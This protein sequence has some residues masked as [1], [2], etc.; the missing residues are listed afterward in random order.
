MTIRYLG[1]SSR[2]DRHRGGSPHDL[3]P[4]QLDARAHGNDRL[5]L[6]GRS[7]SSHT[8]ERA[9]RATSAT[10]AGGRRHHANGKTDEERLV[11]RRVAEGTYGDLHRAAAIRPR[12][13]ALA[14][15]K[16]APESEH[17]DEADP[18]YGREFAAVDEYASQ[19]A[20]YRTDHKGSGPRV[21]PHSDARL[22]EAV[23]ARLSDDAYIDARHVTLQCLHGIIILNGTVSSS[24]ARRRIEKMI[25]NC[26]GVEHIKNRLAVVGSSSD[27]L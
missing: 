25:R 4:D 5:T 2:K 21:A 7:A 15:A 11:R 19:T 6:A 14:P 17:Y 27:R 16:S 23:R 10:E 18:W 8:D 20:M 9:R 3:A 22:A 24:T 1:R 26:P 12:R 13:G